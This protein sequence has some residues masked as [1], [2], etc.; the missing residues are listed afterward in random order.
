MKLLSVLGIEFSRLL[1]YKAPLTQSSLKVNFVSR[2][3]RLRFRLHQRAQSPTDTASL[4]PRDPSHSLRTDDAVPA[5]LQQAGFV[6]SCNDPFACPTPPW[7]ASV[8]TSCFTGQT[9]QPRGSERRGVAP[10][11]TLSAAVQVVLKEIEKLRL[12]WIL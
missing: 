11:L 7:I 10:G 2:L 3:E 12:H 4:I 8:R 1:D 6:V 5:F 9:H